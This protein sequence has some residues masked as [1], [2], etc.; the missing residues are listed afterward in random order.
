[1]MW[2][3]WPIERVLYLLLGVCFLVFFAQVT[4]FHMRQNFR[5]PAMWL[6]VIA[7][8]VVGV[9]AV[10]LAWRDVQILQT[11]LAWLSGITAA[12][13]VYGTYLHSVGVGERVGGYNINNAMVG[14]PVMLPLLLATLSV[15]ALFT[16]IL[17]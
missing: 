3:G 13:S 9:V 14:P 16:V 5:H 2:H 15:I 11:T 8:P 4:L 17:L 10:L 7:T 12:A 1:M 6:P